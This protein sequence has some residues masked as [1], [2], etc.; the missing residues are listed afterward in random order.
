MASSTAVRL[1]NLNATKKLSTSFRH[2][3]TEFVFGAEALENNRLSNSTPEYVLIL[4]AIELALKAFLA[5]QGFTANKLR[6]E[7][8]HDLGPVFS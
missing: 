1:S 7:Y 2:G 8:G 4:H 5:K 3:A 6:K